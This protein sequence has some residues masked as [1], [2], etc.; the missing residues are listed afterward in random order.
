MVRSIID[1]A[2]TRLRPILMAALAASLV[3]VPM[4]INVDT[5]AEV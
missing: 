4:P 5:G 2:L 1:S 3:F